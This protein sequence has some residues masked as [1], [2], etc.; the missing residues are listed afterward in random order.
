ML[1]LLLGSCGSSN[2]LQKYYTSEDN[3]VVELVD[4]ISKNASDKEALTLL[5]QA[6]TQTLNSRQNLSIATYP[7]L[8]PGDKY[9]AL[10]KEWG[11][12][13]QLYDKISAVPA[14]A[15]A[16]TNLW[17]PAASIADARNKAA[18]EFYS[19]G[20]EYLTYDNRQASRQAYDQFRRANEIIPGYENSRMMMEEALER[21]T[22]KVVVRAPD[23]YNHSW[24]HWGLQ[25]DW[26]QQQMI[27][28]LNAQSYRDVRFYSDW[29]ANSRRIRPDRIV[30][31]RFTD[32]FVGQVYNNRRTIQRSKQIETGSTK[33]NPPQPIFTTVRATVYLTERYM[34]SR[35]M[36]ECRIYDYAT[37]RNILFDNF[38]GNDNWRVQTATYTGDSR[39]LLAEDWALI[40]N[41]GQIQT[42][43]R[44]QVADRLIR[45]CYGML[46][47]RIRNGVQF[48]Y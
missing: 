33:S 30:D 10:V 44:A 47:N 43:T 2:R 22:I 7:G 45:D 14:A 38:P 1:L 37:G 19:Q 28:D 20:L 26:L 35:A 15:R 17:N 5:P 16:V 31:M 25:N 29:D 48:G 46:I 4:R 42:P 6:Y 32:L 40:N 12:M 34:T 8:A 39:A 27:N 23:Y 24:N 21:A 41:G 3:A 13:Q 11:V 36:L 18:K 9:L